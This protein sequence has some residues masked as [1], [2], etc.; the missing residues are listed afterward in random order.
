MRTGPTS[1]NGVE[2]AFQLVWSTACTWTRRPFWSVAL[3][4][5]VSWKTTVLLLKEPPNH[6]VRCPVNVASGG[7]MMSALMMLP[8]LSMTTFR[9]ARGRVGGY[10]SGAGERLSEPSVL[11]LVDR[12]V[13]HTVASEV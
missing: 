13:L 7:P 8:W 10:R 1:T 4:V 3:T 6:C 2:V 5:I 9:Q 11:R 12:D